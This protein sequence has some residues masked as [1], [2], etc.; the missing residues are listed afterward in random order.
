MTLLFTITS[1]QSLL[2]Q[3]WSY[4][5]KSIDS[6]SDRGKYK[7]ALAIADSSEKIILTQKGSN[8]PD[9]ASN[10]NEIGSMYRRMSQYT[11]SESYYQKALSLRE[12]LFGADHPDVAE[13]HRPCR[14][15]PAIKHED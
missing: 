6:L 9:Y 3:D 10:E 7:E 11:K 4:F 2:C 5:K 12:K 14:C 13:S 15:S 1:F 8:H